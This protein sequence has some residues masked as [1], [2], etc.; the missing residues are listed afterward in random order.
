MNTPATGNVSFNR[1]EA[2]GIRSTGDSSSPLTG[3]PQ[4]GSTF[5]P[6]HS[7][8]TTEDQTHH[9]LGFVEKL[10][11]KSIGTLILTTLAMAAAV[12][13]LGF[14]WWIDRSNVTW[15]KIV[16]HN[17]LPR[18]VTLCSVVIRFSIASQAVIATS[19]LAALAFSRHRPLLHLSASLSVM[20]FVNT[21]PSSM[22]PMLFKDPSGVGRFPVWVFAIILAC[23]TSL[24]QF[25]STILLSDF[26]DDLVIGTLGNTSTLSGYRTIIPSWSPQVDYWGVVPQT[27]P[28]FAEYSEPQTVQDGM[29]DTGLML[30]TLFPIYSQSTR[31]LLHSF[32]GNG[33][34]IDSRVTCVRP[35][36]VEDSLTIEW[37]ADALTGQDN[38][39]ISGSVKP[40]MLVPRLINT[41]ENDSTT[42]FKCTFMPTDSQFDDTT[43]WILS[44]CTLDRSAGGLL[45]ELD[46]YHNASM[47]YCFDDHNGWQMATSDGS[48]PT[49][50]YDYTPPDLDS[51]IAFFDP[52]FMGSAYLVLNI[53]RV[54]FGDFPSQN[55]S[56]FNFNTWVFD[57]NGPWLEAKLSDPPIQIQ[58]TLCYDALH[59]FDLSVIAYSNVN[60]TEPYVRYD[61]ETANFTT[62]TVRSQLGTFKNETFDQRG[63]LSL[64]N[65][66]TELRQQIRLF[67]PSTN[68][69]EAPT[70]FI[71]G[72]VL[73][74]SKTKSALF[75]PRCQPMFDTLDNFTTVVNPQQASTF[76]DNLQDTARPAL[77]VQAH[78]T[79]LARM[80]YYDNL[81]IFDYPG[82]QLSDFFTP[83]SAPTTY[84][85]FAIV[86]ALIL[87]HLILVGTLTVIFIKDVHSTRLGNIWHTVARLNSNETHALLREATLAS[88]GQVRK[89]LEG[90][91]TV[92]RRVTLGSGSSGRSNRVEIS[93]A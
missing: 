71:V 8:W 82:T 43:P 40:A 1:N 10:G 55:S 93:G 87:I 78:F 80:A 66:P 54:S 83:A 68:L 79:T 37:T 14:L 35:R 86:M 44:I 84:K 33:T 17:W 67:F 51:A 58:S 65:N 59:S 46:P 81:P 4:D 32:R 73:P 38:S 91:G 36:F 75:C 53:S 39:Y 11:P 56:H 61:T 6:S 74:N 31:S 13:F 42:Q 30:R 52:P 49:D 9:Q 25:S 3:E 2:K 69:G 18:S 20:R 7:E 60:R 85:G 50:R 88:D 90:D 76:R 16:L 5:H 19:M 77:A 72:K 22:V 21:G 57:S 45:S 41:F 28:T 63:I 89:W 34:V 15:R 24:S 29:D 62:K 48:Y 47:R 92:T 23:T 26:H 27:Y 70:S 12:S 64:Q